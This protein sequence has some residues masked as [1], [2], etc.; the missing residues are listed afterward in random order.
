MLTF[1]IF[2]YI[3]ITLIIGF[4]AA[5]G[6]KTSRDFTLAGRGLST[7]FV[8]VTIFATWFGSHQIIG[9]P[10]YFVKSGFLSFITLTVAPAICLLIVGLFYSKPLY[11]MNIVTVGDFFR[12]RYNKKLDITVSIILVL[13]YFQWIAAQF[14]AL[15]FLFQ[16]VL[17]ISTEYGILLGALIVIIYT[18]VGGMLA[19][20]YMD[21]LQS[22]FILI[23]LVILLFN[24]LELTD[25]IS[26]LFEKK[27]ESFFC[28]FPKPEIGAWS[29]YL[30]TIL[31]FTVG[32]ISAQEIYQRV[33]SA[34]S[35]KAAV[36]GTFL[37]AILML[38]I[39]IIPLIIALGAAF[40]NPELMNVDQGQS[41]IP[42]A[43][44]QYVSLPVQVLFYGALI[45]AI[46]S[47]SSG[48]ILAPAT[49]IAK[50]LLQPY[51]T[52]LS[53]KLLLLWTRISVVLV[54]GISCYFSFHSTNVVGLVVA[55]VSLLLVCVFVP[56]TFGLFW[57]KASIYGA[58]TAIIA[59]GVVWLLCNIIETEIDAS[60]YGLAAS[61]FGIVTGSLFRPE[62]S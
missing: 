54:A 44:A 39:P 37:A 46:L 8:G 30:A 21:M 4:W 62:S 22:I 17:G 24:I 13:T 33:F 31:A 26:P 36:Q 1:F 60:I 19:V 61:C 40:L 49:I 3:V 35:E 14:V 7:S 12:I 43:V 20:S 38:I 29:D 16:T 55:S 48:A 15:S 56:F 34:K 59:G 6:I 42:D 52:T 58:W 28:F 53:D 57:K 47:T 32:A 9:N 10:G 27:P 41:I 18:Y 5:Q 51:F 45:S 2:I 11:R 23:G 25:G 50:N